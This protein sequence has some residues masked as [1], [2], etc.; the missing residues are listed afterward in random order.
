MFSSIFPCFFLIF[1]N[2]KFHIIFFR[3]GWWR[4]ILLALVLSSPSLSS[5]TESSPWKKIF[6]PL[7]PSSP[8]HISLSPE[9]FCRPTIDIPQ[10]ISSY[11]KFNTILLLLESVMFTSNNRAI[12]FNS[13]DGTVAHSVQGSDI[14]DA[15]KKC[16]LVGSPYKIYSK[17]WG[18]ARTLAEGFVSTYSE[19]LALKLDTSSGNQPITQDG[20]AISVE[21]QVFDPLYPYLILAKNDAKFGSGTQS[22]KNV[23][24]VSA[25]IPSLPQDLN[26]VKTAVRDQLLA[27]QSV[28]AIIR[29]E[30]RKAIPSFSNLTYTLQTAPNNSIHLIR[31]QDSPLPQDCLQVS[32]KIAPTIS[33]LSLPTVVTPLNLE[34]STSLLED[35]LVDCLDFTKNILSVLHALNKPTDSPPLVLSY[36]FSSHA[37]LFSF[38]PYNSPAR[39]LLIILISSFAGSVLLLSFCF[40][41]FCL[42]ARRGS[43]ILRNTENP[44]APIQ[45]QL[46]NTHRSQPS[47]PLL[48][49]TRVEGQ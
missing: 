12:Y 48:G 32:V 36:S 7:S 14:E 44:P 24:C 33:S 1:T 40:L 4:F 34:V 22:S 46:I 9:L 16:E 25:E 18:F 30:L 3:S 19:D 29:D 11:N 39:T 49:I 43:H 31:L 47:A 8:S 28:G 35:R 27:L 17:S 15:I 37:Q 10:A 2:V 13:S 5:E 41:S 20:V 38:L 6:S 23:V 45:F 21:N 26:I 42:L